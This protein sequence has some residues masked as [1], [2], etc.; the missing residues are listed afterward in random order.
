MSAAPPVRARV[1]AL[2]ATPRYAGAAVLDGWGLAP[3]G[4]ETWDLR[5][6]RSLD[7][8]TDAVVA[9]VR[10]LLLRHRPARVVVGVPVRDDWRCAIMRDRLSVFLRGRG[11]PVRERL[12]RDARLILL[13]RERGPER[14]ALA[15]ALVSGFLPELSEVTTRGPEGTRYRSHGWEA[16]AL[17][18]AELV[19]IAPRAAC[20]LARP[21]AC[22]AEPFRQAVM[23]SDRRRHPE[24]ERNA[25]TPPAAPHVGQLRLFVEQPAVHAA[26]ETDL[27]THY[28]TPSHSSAC[29]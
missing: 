5:G 11:Q 19:E 21:G 24:P 18:V 28:V 15:R 1:L 14:G 23:A 6:R 27:T 13:G 12:S 17:A 25:S 20:A 3:G 9:R 10:Y 22:S 26:R 29:P 7:A 2:V 8:K 16:A 4:F